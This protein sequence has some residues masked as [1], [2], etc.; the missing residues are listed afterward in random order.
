MSVQMP[1]LSENVGASKQILLPLLGAPSERRSRA[2]LDPLR[3]ARMG[4]AA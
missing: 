1:A 4:N 2:E 3:A